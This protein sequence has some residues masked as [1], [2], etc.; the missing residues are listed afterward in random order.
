MIKGIFRMARKIRDSKL[1]TRTAR[2]K[3][4]PRPKPYFRTIQEGRAIGYRRIEGKAG[5]WIAQFYDPASPGDGRMQRALGSADDFIDADGGATMTFAQAQDVA[6]L[7]FAEI[8]LAGREKPREPITVAQAMDAY[9]SEYV[10]KGGRDSKR[11]RQVS[12]AHIILALGNKLV[13]D[14]T[15]GDINGWLNKLATSPAML[16]TKAGKQRNVRPAEDEDAKRAR[17]ASANR[18]LTVL[19]AALN[20]A[21]KRGDV[22]S[23]T[24]W[25]RVKPFAKVDAPRIR[26]MEDAEAVRLDNACPSD[27]RM[28]VR[29]AL[30][31]GADWS[32]LA[33]ATVNDLHSDTSTLAVSGKRG[34]RT[35]R[36]SEEAK[37]HFVSATDRVPP[38]GVRACVIIPLPGGLAGAV[39]RPW[40][41]G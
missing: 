11:I 34:Q 37:A 12:N 9:L 28:I 23:D 35:I 26:W 39:S 21:W 29:A 25:R 2:L 41:A 31:T 3:L 36:L 20:A 8:V 38:S 14:L 15:P 16:R 19:K 27:F 10:A 13:K 7:W 18:I 6:V 32:E 4:V 24:A 22:D 5:T 1:D 30:L 33:N 17:R 40:R